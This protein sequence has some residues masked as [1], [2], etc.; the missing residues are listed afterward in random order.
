MRTQMRTQVS[1]NI[2]STVQNYLF[3]AIYIPQQ[4]KKKPGIY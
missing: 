3:Y 1:V 4:N 2:Q